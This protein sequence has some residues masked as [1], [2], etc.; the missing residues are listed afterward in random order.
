MV[1]AELFVINPN[2]VLGINCHK[3]INKVPM[4]KKY[5]QYVSRLLSQETIKKKPL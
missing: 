3:E 1:N 5:M 2:S 4:S